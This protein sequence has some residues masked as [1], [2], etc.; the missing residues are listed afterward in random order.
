MSTFTPYSNQAQETSQLANNTQNQLIPDTYQTNGQNISRS[1]GNQGNSNQQ[2]NR[3]NTEIKIIL[4][5]IPKKDTESETP[6]IP[7]GDFKL[8]SKIMDCPFCKKK[9][10]TNTK[11][12]MNIKAFLIALGTCYCGFAIM[13]ACNHKSV[14]MDDCEHSCPKC[15]RIIGTYYAV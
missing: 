4:P 11:K 8:E 14:S 2:I 6:Y 10:A 7:P 13:Q 15:G 5:E 9:I 3:T 1:Q 12:S